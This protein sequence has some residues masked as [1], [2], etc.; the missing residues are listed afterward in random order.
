MSNTGGLTWDYG[1]IPYQPCPYQWERRYEGIRKAQKDWGL[2]G[3]MEC[4]HYGWWPSFISELEKEAFTEGGIPFEEHLRA[5]AARDFGNA[6]VERALEAWRLWSDTARDYVASDA[7]QYGPFRLGPAY[8]Y[9]FGGKHIETNDFPCPPYASF[10]V[11]IARLNYL[12][13]SGYNPE[14]G[15]H[16]KLN[17][18]AMAKELELLESM[19]DKLG[20]GASMFD[21][22]AARLPAARAAR[23]RRM[24][25][26][27][28][29]MERT[30]ITAINVKRG[31]IAHLDGDKDKVMEYAVREY[32]NAKAALPLVAEDSRLGWEPSM[33][34]VGGVEQVQWKL[35]R[36]VET[37]GEAVKGA[38]S[39][40]LRN[41]GFASADGIAPDSW[42]A[43]RSA[44]MK[45]AF[46]CTGGVLRISACAPAYCHGVHQTID[47]DGSKSHWFE[48]DIMCDTLMYN[49]N[50]RYTLLDAAGKPVLSDRPLLH[51]HFSGPQKKWFRVGLPIPAADASR[52][53]RLRI[54]FLVY[55]GS[56]KPAEDRALY[57][58][59]PSVTE[60][61]GQEYKP[62]PPP[63]PRGDGKLPLQPF[64]GLPGAGR[65]YVIERGGVGYLNLR[66]P[67]IPRGKESE[68][69]VEVPKGVTY[70][71]HL[72]NINVIR[73]V[74]RCDEGPKGRFKLPGTVNWAVGGNTL[75][76]A[77]ADDV[78]DKFSIKLTFSIGGEQREAVVPVEIVG[79]VK[80]AALPK[81]CR[82][83]SWTERPLS[84][85]DV[86]NSPLGKALAEYWRGTGW[87]S[88][89]TVNVT[90]VFPYRDNLKDPLARKGVGPHGTPTGIPCDSDLQAKGA[91]YYCERLKKAG[92]AES[93][94]GTEFAVWDYEPYV[95][96]PVTTGC[97]CEDCRRAF[98]KETGLADT[99]S[100][101]SI[102]ES[103]KKEW[104]H[105][106]CRQRAE[107]VRIAVAG[108]KMLAPKVKFALCTMPMAPGKGDPQ[109]SD[110]FDYLERFGIDSPLYE[111]F[112]DVYCSMN[113]SSGLRYFRGLEREMNCLGKPKMT[114]LE[115]GWG[116]PREG[117]VLGM[118]LAAAFFAG[119][120]RPYIAQGLDISDGDQ[121]SE[122]RRAMAFVA[123]TEDA[124][125]GSAFRRDK[126]PCS[127][128]SGKAESFWSMDR[129]GGDGTRYVLAFNSSCDA[130]LTVEVSPPAG[131]AGETQTVVLEPCAYR[132]L[133]F[134]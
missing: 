94:A 84:E 132:L 57:I 90:G 70:E 98:A 104:V 78:P 52:V 20:R 31:A 77:A 127:V 37:Y 15:E 30:V 36:M 69:A 89:T 86:E 79:R 87:E 121:L 14:Y 96:G 73:K 51:P 43:S 83:R 26:L 99:P 45:G 7:N 13:L 40:K 61:V 11:R 28:H 8:P 19:R 50:I 112:T 85:I 111:D 125:R 60:Y 74:F 47:I 131:R 128:K 80:P 63:G 2:S 67:T 120:E 119:Q 105:F 5:I 62:L 123:E 103:H 75:L 114:L 44:P 64:S 17:L 113:Y 110:D 3:L 42:A 4:H 1:V 95:V 76:F 49:A 126:F 129:E 134:R 25:G 118:Q 59:N 32:A 22:I 33:E 92:L 10:G 54:A 55:N 16:K 93:L 109:F 122:I 72:R 65:K 100:A 9:N 115:N 106:R 68:L 91:A 35:D 101:R 116:T 124:W 41:P 71:L 58:R 102:L 34:Y 21:D 97:F 24:A 53:R 88:A 6:N 117:K 12:D 107:S 81:A 27:G 133:K 48:A 82:Y 29:F 38:V 18:P 130:P 46:T 56:R 23:A 39:N 66:S 108:L